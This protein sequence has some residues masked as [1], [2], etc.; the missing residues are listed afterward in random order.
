LDGLKNGAEGPDGLLVEYSVDEGTIKVIKEE[1]VK[2]LTFGGEAA[3]EDD[4][5]KPQLPAENAEEAPDVPAPI[6]EDEDT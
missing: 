5:D 3:D 6:M 1:T 4:E 2:L